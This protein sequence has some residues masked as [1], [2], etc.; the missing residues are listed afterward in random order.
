MNL[1]EFESRLN[2][3]GRDQVPFL[4][5]VDFEMENLRAWKTREVPPDIL[6]SMSGFTGKS[7]QLNR[8]NVL[9]EK[10]PIPFPEYQSK[11]NIVKDRIGFGDS[12][13]TNLT[14]KTK[15][16]LSCSLEELFYRSEAKYKI[17]WKN[18]FLVFSPETF[19]QVTEGRI[20]S[21]PMKGT[22]DASLPNAETIIVNDPKELSEHVTIVD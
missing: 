22:I 18:R 3:W 5:L 6:F 13:L 20:Y 11:F 2:E 19:I 16:N 9:L 15:I 1:I 17:C 4:F 14:I 8:K 21:F 7:R 12:Y 10:F